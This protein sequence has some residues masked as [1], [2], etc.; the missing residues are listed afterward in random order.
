MKGKALYYLT[1]LCLLS[2]GL[3]WAA[4]DNEGSAHPSAGTS[5]VERNYS[6]SAMN[7]VV[8]PHTADVQL[9]IYPIRSASSDTLVV[10]AGN[11]LGRLGRS[12]TGFKVIRTASTAVDVYWW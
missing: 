8:H 11:T 1:A 7:L 12:H 2:A 9:I 3:V 10:R 5:S 4:V 6:A